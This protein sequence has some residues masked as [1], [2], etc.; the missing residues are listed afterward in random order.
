LNKLAAEAAKYG[1][2]TGLKNA[3]EILPSV[4][5]VIQF[6]VNEQCSSDGSCTSYDGFGKPVYHLEYSN[7]HSVSDSQ[8]DT[9]CLAGAST[10]SELTTVIK[11]LNLDGW[12]LYCDGQSAT[13]PTYSDGVIKGQHEC[14][15]N[16]P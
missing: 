11:T 15:A 10:A 4:N 9:L 5:S 7:D 16:S 2:S 3:E 14:P 8:K 1:M 13:S 12:V 6:A